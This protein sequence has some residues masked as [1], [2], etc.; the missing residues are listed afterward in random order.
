MSWMEDETI[1]RLDS[2]GY[3]FGAYVEGEAPILQVPTN[4]LLEEEEEEEEE[5]E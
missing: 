1:A 5:E 3:N 2:M 4:P